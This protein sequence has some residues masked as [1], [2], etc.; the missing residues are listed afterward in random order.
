MIDSLDIQ[1]GAST[2]GLGAQIQ[3]VVSNI[4]SVRDA[5]D[6]L[7]SF[8]K[9]VREGFRESFEAGSAQKAASE[10][11][12]AARAA[13]HL[14]DELRKADRAADDLGKSTK[15]VHL[16]LDSIGG[17]AGRVFAA[18]GIY[19]IGK[20]TIETIANF[21]KL[22]SV[23][24]TLEGKEVAPAC[25]E[26]LRKFAAETPFDLEQ[27]VTA[28]TKLKSQ[29]LDPG[30]EALRAYGNIAS[31]MGKNLDQFIEA[32]ADAAMG[33]FER[34]KEFGIKAK[35][36]G[37]E[38]TFTFQGV[39]T[40]VG[41]NSEDIQKYLQNIGNTNFAG[42][43]ENQMKTL[44]GAF[45]NLGD[46]LAMIADQ[47]GQGGLS[48]AIG[49]IVGDMNEA[50]STSENWAGILGSVLGTVLTTIWDLV[51]TL[52]S[53]ISDVFST[54]ANIFRETTG[55]TKSDGDIWI[56]VIKGIE[57]VF[58]VLAEVVQVTFTIIGGVLRW[59]IET[60]TAAARAIEAAMNFDFSG[61]VAAVR[62]WGSATVKIAEDTANKVVDIHQK[63]QGKVQGIWAQDFSAKGS[64]GAGTALPGY[65]PPRPGARTGGGPRGG[66]GGAGGAKRSVVQEWEEDLRHMHVLNENYLQD[67]T[68][69]DLAYWEGK[70]SLTRQGSD[71]WYAVQEK[72]YNL[73]KKLAQQEYQDQQQSLS[74]QM[75]AAKGN[76]EIQYS[77]MVQKVELAR[78]TYGED[79]REYR[80]ALREKERMQQE[81]QRELI[82]LERQGI[83]DRERM[84]Q[85]EART[86][87][88]LSRMHLDMERDAID[89]LENAGLMGR[90]RAAAERARLDQLEIQSRIETE[91]RI[92]EIK[93]QSLRDQMALYPMDASERARINRDME[94]AEAEHQQ[95]MRV[96]SAQSAQQVQQSQRAAAEATRQVWLDRLMPVTQALNSMINGFL[97]GTMTMRQAV[98]QIGSQ[99]LQQVTQWVMNWVT[100]H[101]AAEQAKTAAT[102]AGNAARTASNTAA[103]AAQMGTTAA[104]ATGEITTNAAVAGS[105]AL[106]SISKIPVI[107]PFI[108]PAIAAGILALAMGF[109]GKIA[110]AEG[111]WDQVPYDGMMTELHKD[112]MVL[113][114]GIAT[115]LRDALASKDS[116]WS[117]GAT[118]L[119]G[120]QIPEGMTRQSE[121][122]E[123][124]REGD[125]HFHL[126]ALDTRSGVDWLMKN[127]R[128]IG[129]ALG[130]A[131]REGARD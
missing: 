52:G 70:L 79:S 118:G 106:A 24:T 68:K 16:S 96:L 41:K 102:V 57:A 104:T 23:L 62:D 33:E 10:I 86:D 58:V 131:Y 65:T 116:T 38:V 61:A 81:H 107:G 111:G 108:A 31:G 84:R 45:S 93:M 9:G 124:T 7:E 130:R 15:G 3:T 76:Y 94:I 98:L 90:Q 105:G 82:Q 53:V 101:V 54:I 64:P 50:G 1:I 88:E 8:L 47:I 13:D 55:S 87:I 99:I 12:G 17:M 67:S 127:R 77:F 128:T 103:A 30:V 95:K 72:V 40:T 25:F 18:I 27:V 115:P 126:S 28:F 22:R 112:E 39:S 49:T 92:Y 4:H 42:A 121:T 89:D 73:R 125:T 97:Q 117:L 6:A 44:G 34:L 74:D 119:A 66:T 60:F 63:A 100:Q 75:D 43:M 46:N 20:Q 120:R 36:T 14:G 2:P 35:Q 69:S 110:S 78:Q 123:Y 26:S 129:K 91:N 37:D 83:Q 21:E 19:E 114:A 122:Q 85:D 80:Q 32:T 113:P 11:E 48:S 29:G 51:K 71:E 109:I 56:S 59:A 5:V